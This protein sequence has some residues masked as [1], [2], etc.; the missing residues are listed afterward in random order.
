LK[1]EYTFLAVFVVVFAIIIALLA[2]PHGLGTFWTTTAFLVG[3]LTSIAA[4]YIGM[5]I[6]VVANIKTTK[7]CAF[8]IHRGF[9]VAYKAGSVLG[10]M[11]VG[12]CLLFLL[13]II[14]LYRNLM[15]PKDLSNPA[16]KIEAYL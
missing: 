3:A 14:Y 9:V 16:V 15:L 1:S 13:L 7:E 8:S 4:G 12:L 6:A 5:R 11:L 10:F 2:E